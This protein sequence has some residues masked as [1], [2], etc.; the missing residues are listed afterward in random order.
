MEPISITPVEVPPAAAPAPKKEKK[1]KREKVAEKTAEEIREQRE[2][3]ELDEFL[4]GLL[5]TILVGFVAENNY[6]HIQVSSSNFYEYLLRFI[7][8]S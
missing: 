2:R 6:R 4:G 7:W 8:I 3:D 5:N 1:K